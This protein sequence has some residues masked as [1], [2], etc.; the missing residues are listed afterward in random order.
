MREVGEGAEVA[1]DDDGDDDDGGVAD[2]DDGDCDD[3]EPGL[4][5]S[6]GLLGLLESPGPAINEPANSEL[7]TQKAIARGKSL[8]FILFPFLFVF[9]PHDYRH[10]KLA[11]RSETIFQP[12]SPG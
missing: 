10:S 5:G 2:G 11:R 3:E 4:L 8:S 9:V 7:V 1:D 6:L 12:T